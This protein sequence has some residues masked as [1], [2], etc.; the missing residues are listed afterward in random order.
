METAKIPFLPRISYDTEPFWKACSEHKLIF[1][2]CD[3]CGTWRWPAAFLCPV[4][5]SPKF[6][7]TESSGKGKIYSFIVFHRAFHHNLEEMVPYVVASIQLE[8]GPRFL[9]NVVGCDPSEVE[10]EKSVELT[11]KDNGEGVALPVFKL[12]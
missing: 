9:S 5:L 3:N 7:W 10:C 12:G 1:Q 11:W 4:C 2:K 8:E 6:T